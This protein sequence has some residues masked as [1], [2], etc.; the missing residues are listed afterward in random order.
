[1]FRRVVVAMAVSAM[2][3]GLPLPA[4]AQDSVVQVEIE[5]CASCMIWASTADYS[6]PYR[7]W[8]QNVRLRAGKGVLSVPDWVTSMQIGVEKG[9]WSGPG[10]SSQIVFQYWGEAPG[11]PISYKRARSSRAG[12]MCIAPAP[13]LVIQAK[14]VLRKTKRYKGWKKDPLFDHKEVLVWASPTLQGLGTYNKYGENNAIATQR[15]LIGTQNTVCGD[16][17]R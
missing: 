8:T 13:D 9:K 5:D 11:L 2:A 6:Y 10:V 1:M 3:M 7:G 16:K 14:A 4:Q 17:Y 12:F 15:G